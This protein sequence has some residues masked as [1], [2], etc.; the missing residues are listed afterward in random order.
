MTEHIQSVQ[1]CN[2][3]GWLE[4]AVPLWNNAELLALKSGQLILTHPDV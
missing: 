2:H 4:Q 1:E 3:Y